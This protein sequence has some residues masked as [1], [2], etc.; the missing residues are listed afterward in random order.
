MDSI[1]MSVPDSGD[2]RPRDQSESETDRD[3]EIA[4]SLFLESNDGLFL[5]DPDDQKLV[6]LNPAA[7][8]MTGFDRKS[9]LG[10]PLTDLFLSND[11]EYLDRLITA[12]TKT[13]F[14]H[15]R[16]DYFLRRLEGSALAVNISLSRIHT[17]PRPLGLAVVRDVSDRRRAQIEL[18]RFFR[19]SPALLCI[20]E[21]DGHFRKVNDAW[22]QTLGYSAQE[23][24]SMRFSDLVNS[25]SS[26]VSQQPDPSSAI[27]HQLVNLLTSPGHTA[28]FEICVDRKSGRCRWLSCRA[29][30]VDG[31]VYAAAL[32]I[33]DAKLSDEFRRDKELAEAANQAKGRFLAQVSHELRT[34]LTAILGLVDLLLPDTGAPRQLPDRI[35]DL[36]II[37]RNG[38]HLLELINVILDLSKIESGRLEVTR[39]LCEPARIAADVL[40][41]MT[42]RAESKGLTLR[43]ERIGT[44]PK[45]IRTDPVRFRQVLINLVDNAIK[46]TGRGVV[47]IRMGMVAEKT[48]PEGEPLLRVEVIDTGIG[49]TEFEIPSLFQPFH[50]ASSSPHRTHKGTGLGLAISRSLAE[51]LGGS[52]TVASEPGRGSVFTLEIAAG[53]PPADEP[54]ADH[55]SL[56]PQTPQQSPPDPTQV[57]TSVDPNLD[58]AP[59]FDSK[60]ILLVEDNDDARRAFV[61]RLLKL[62]LQ[63]EAAS[64]GQEACDKA[65]AALAAQSPFDWVLMDMQMPVIDGFEAT[66]RLRSAGYD[67][68]I[69]AMTAY[70][71][72][73]DRRDCLRFGCDGYISKPIDWNRL[74]TI[75]AQLMIPKPPTN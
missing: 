1:G 60:R 67:R 13:Q 53:T 42:V 38:D 17:K 55:A 24:K 51:L 73:Q 71:T 29:T 30:A 23:L 41:L 27:E 15:S 39:V 33:S 11:P 37:K 57:S 2:E 43:A 18:D 14:F 8:R 70:A 10:M 59:D 9:A 49:I 52:V 28:Q 61:P 12:C 19:L 34:P 46:F 58:R 75:L 3:R 35:E 45:T 32:D 7:L 22:E 5:F 16:E 68:P 56:T 44:I 50:Q 69:I 66:R 47:T 65:L 20:L 54:P 6:D 48:S 64:D 21:P 25:N 63:V 40:S 26:S 74:T 36:Q 31:Q 72:E 62:G 4:R